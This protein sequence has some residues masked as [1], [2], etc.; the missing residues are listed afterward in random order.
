[1]A[2]R[3]S[4][5]I[6]G[7]LID[8]K[9]HP[10]LSYFFHSDERKR[11][12]PDDRLSA[13]EIGR[14]PQKR[15]FVSSINVPSGFAASSGHAINYTSFLVPCSGYSFCRYMSTINQGSDDIEFTKDVA[16]VL[17]DTTM[18]AVASQAPVLSEVAVAAA[19][20]YLPVQALQYLI[21]YVHTFTGLNW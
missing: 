20:S 4:L 9:C 2:Y 18:E 12:C 7:K 13:A 3:R 5:L 15:S 6:R 10:S 16:N 21:D 11:E 8:Q 14:L 1:M 17:S 19:D